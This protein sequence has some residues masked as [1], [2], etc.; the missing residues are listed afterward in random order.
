MHVV[1]VSGSSVTL[2][3]ITSVELPRLRHSPSGF[4]FGDWVSV[5]GFTTTGS[6]GEEDL[7][8]IG[9]STGTTEVR[10]SWFSNEGEICPE[11]LSGRLR[12]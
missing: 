7:H 8:A 3:G 6:H 10:C 9:F 11:H 1:L 4:G 12:G 5:I 2:P